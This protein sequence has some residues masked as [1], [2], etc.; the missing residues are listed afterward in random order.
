MR[1]D[2]LEGINDDS[3]YV[4][5]PDYVS[6]WNKD[7]H[8]QKFSKETI[9]NHARHAMQAYIRTLVSSDANSN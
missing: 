6:I 9:S 2:I 8:Y 3:F 1:K 7:D 5:N 4:I